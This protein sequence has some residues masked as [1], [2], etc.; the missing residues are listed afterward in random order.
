VT[1]YSPHGLLALAAAVGLLTLY[2]IARAARA[3]TGRLADY[4]DNDHER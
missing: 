1:R 4:F 2:G 3:V